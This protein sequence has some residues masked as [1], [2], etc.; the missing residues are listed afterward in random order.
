M[1]RDVVGYEG[2]YQVSN[3]GRI[4]ILEKIYSTI[5]NKS[6]IKKQRFKKSYLT[7]SLWKK[8]KAKTFFVH[9]LVANAFIEIIYNKTFV[10][11][12]NGNKADNRVENLEWVTASENSIHSARVLGNVKRGEDSPFNKKVYQYS[13]KG[14]LIKVYPSLSIAAKENGRTRTAISYCCLGKTETCNGFVWST[15]PIDKIHFLN[16]S[17]LTGN[18]RVVAMCDDNLSIVK[19]YNSIADAAKEFNI[20]STSII[21]SIK[22]GGKCMNYKWIY[23]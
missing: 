22:R 18:K 9:R 13:M 21:N 19:I 5:K 4:K 1:W 16:K 6:S 14:D 20:N 12:K 23:T 10:N 11:H 15:N 3:M 8:C 17:Y 2:L 7:V